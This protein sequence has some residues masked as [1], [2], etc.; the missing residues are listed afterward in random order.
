M[1]AKKL[2]GAARRKLARQAAREAAVKSSAQGEP[3]H[4]P[5]MGRLETV[6]DIAREMRR[7][8]HEVRMKKLEPARAAR[9]A[10][11][12]MLALK[13]TEVEI[14]LHHRAAIIEAY[15]A[16]YG[17]RNQSNLSSISTKR[18][19]EVQMPAS[20]DAVSVIPGGSP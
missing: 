4:V 6:G 14:E 1:A 2:S 17:R 18:K 10:Y 9:E 8:F 11:V 13:A 16:K 7:V 3:Q 12:G 15:R 19:A 5:T 20:T